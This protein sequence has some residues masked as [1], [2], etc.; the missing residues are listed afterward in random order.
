[1]CSQVLAAW[2]QGRRRAWSLMFRSAVLQLDKRPTSRTHVASCHASTR[3]ASRGTKTMP[4]FHKIDRNVPSGERAAET[5]T[6]NEESVLMLTWLCGRTG[7][8]L[9]PLKRGIAQQ[10]CRPLGRDGERCGSSECEGQDGGK[11]PGGSGRGNSHV[12]VRER[13]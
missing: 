11:A 9:H 3:A 8:S 5:G 13:Q 2:R 1:M 12:P 6:H 10:S 7:V 4:S